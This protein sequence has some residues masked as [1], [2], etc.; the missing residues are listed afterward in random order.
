MKNDYFVTNLLIPLEQAIFHQGRDPRQKRHVI[1]LVNCSVHAGGASKDWTDEH[2]M[3][4]ILYP[5]YSPNLAPVTSAY[6]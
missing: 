4:R 5:P 2:D 3:R 1:H 6:F